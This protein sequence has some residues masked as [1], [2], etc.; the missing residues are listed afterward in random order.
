CAF[1]LS[2]AT[3]MMLD[4]VSTAQPAAAAPAKSDKS[5]KDK[6]AASTAK[7]KPE[8]PIENVVSVTTDNLVDKP[9]EYFKKNVKFVANFAAFNSL[10]L[11]YKPAMRSSKDHLSF[12]VMR[13]GTKIPYSEL[14]L[15][16]TIP[17]EKDPENQVLAQ[18]KDGDEV[19]ITGNVF[20]TALDEP[21]VDVLRLKKLKSAPDD[22]KSDKSDKSDE[23]KSD[24]KKDD[25]KIDKEK[26][27]E[28]KPD[29][30]PDIAP[31]K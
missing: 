11:D 1:S 17:K 14:K 25:K 19:E 22:K 18:L 20:S 5:D 28:K 6:A 31:K 4:T 29:S 3:A 9:H 10:S 15:A 26:L 23:K 2:T 27:D 7:A 8:P 13:N 24:D 30:P 16:M 12:C 21:W